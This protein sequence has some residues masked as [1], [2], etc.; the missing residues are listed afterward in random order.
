MRP[1]PQTSQRRPASTRTGP[2]TRAVTYP[3][4]MRNRYSGA[5]VEAYSD[6]SAATT[7]RSPGLRNRGW[8]LRS[9]LLRGVLDDG[10]IPGISQPVRSLVTI[11]RFSANPWESKPQPLPRCS[12]SGLVPAE[13][14]SLPEHGGHSGCDA[15]WAA[16]SGCD[17]GTHGCSLGRGRGRGRGRLPRRFSAR[18]RAARSRRRRSRSTRSRSARVIGV[19]GSWAAASRSATTSSA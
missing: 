14:S 3:S 7:R 4:C 11:V 10:R 13:L 18:S 16:A 15:G 5:M 17:V 6:R 8:M 19:S 9:R 12:S 2:A 1:G